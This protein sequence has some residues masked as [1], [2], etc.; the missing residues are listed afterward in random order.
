MT[1]RGKRNIALL[2]AGLLLFMAVDIPGL[3]VNAAEKATQ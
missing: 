2:L 3:Q 1:K